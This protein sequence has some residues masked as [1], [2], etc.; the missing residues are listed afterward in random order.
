M[1]VL[2]GHTE[3][4]NRL[5][6]SPDGGM[7]ASAGDDGC[8]WLWDLYAQTSLARISWGA[9]WVFT[10]A[11][12][13]DGQVLAAGTESSL[14]LLHAEGQDWKPFHQSR[15][16]Q[17]WVTAVAFSSQDQLVA[18]G[19]ADGTVKFW[20]SAQRRKH[21]LRT[22][23]GNL[24]LVRGVAFSPGGPAIA[25]GGTSGIGMW[26]ATEEEPI[27]FHH[28]GDADLRGVAFTADGSALLAPVGRGLLAADLETGQ[29]RSLCRSPG[30]F[31]RS[32]AAAPDGRFLSGRD[33]GV[34]QVWD[35]AGAI[36]CS[37]QWHDGAVNAL[38]VSPTG[39]IAASAGDDF[40]VVVWDL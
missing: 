6:F 39:T 20:D 23:T 12:S 16:H 26:T 38:A 18:S 7:L 35:E 3:P 1:M 14:L 15:E 13:P 2:T 40:D 24:G 33:D 10:I 21:A 8:I 4:V 37:Y 32:V 17:G 31:T 34:V 27:V 30:K 29:T 19:G 5:A 36:A 9:K 25:V 28:L 11:F 22:I